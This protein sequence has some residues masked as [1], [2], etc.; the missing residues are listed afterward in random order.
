MVFASI[1]ILLLILWRKKMVKLYTTHCPQCHTLEIKLSRAGIEYEVCDDVEIMK[2]R[3]FRSV[4][5]LETDD[6]TFNFIEAIK[7]VNNKK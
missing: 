4:P 7:W 5:V 6:G 2:A 3:G 1:V